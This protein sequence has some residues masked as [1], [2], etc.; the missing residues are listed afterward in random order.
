MKINN[1]YKITY[2]PFHYSDETIVFIGTVQRSTVSTR[3]DL[4]G[5]L[6]KNDSGFHNLTI[7]NIVAY[8]QI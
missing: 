4:D 3:S 1:T 7:R 2:K 5:V 8:E 6:I